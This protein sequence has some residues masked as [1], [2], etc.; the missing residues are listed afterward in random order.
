MTSSTATDAATF[1]VGNGAVTREL[2]VRDGR[3]S[4]DALALPDG[5]RIAVT[6]TELALVVATDAWRHDI[7]IW[8][9][10]EVEPGDPF[11]GAAPALDDGGWRIVPH[12]HPVFDSRTV[13]ISWFRA[14]I[15]L[16]AERASGPIHIVL[17]GLDDEDW[18]SYAA[19]LDG[20][21]LDAWTGRGRIRDPRAIVLAPGTPEHA[22]LRFGEP[23]VLAVRVEGLD[24]GEDLAPPRERE[25]VFFQGWLLDQYVSGGA[26]TRVVE[27]FRVVGTE[28]TA[29]G[30]VAV[31]LRSQAAPIEATLRYRGDPHGTRKT[32]EV[33]NVG[34]APLT[35]LDVVGDELRGEIGA[36][37]GGRGQPL[38]IGGT[39]YAGIEHP[40]GV[41]QGDTDRI[42]LVQMPG[43]TIAPGTAWEARPLVIGAAPGTHPLDAFAAY[44]RALRPRPSGRALV[45]SA[46]GWYDFTNP[47]DPLPELTQELLHENL[48]QLRELAGDG[49]PP[50]DV[51]MLDDW[52]EFSD[53]GRFRVAAFP[54]REEPVARAIRDAGMVAGLWWA[55]TRALWSSGT[56]PGVER[57]YANHPDFGGTVA[58]A[59]GTWRWLEEFGNLFIGERRF[60]L[61]SEPYRSMFM[62][63]IPAH[64][65][66]LGVT[67]LKLDCVVLHC[68]S[69]EHDHRPGRHS[70]EPM[71]DALERLLERCRAVSPDLRVVWYWGFRSPWYLGLGEMA[72]D[73]GLLMEAA[74]P[75]STPAP[76]ARQATSLNVD[77]SIEF[78]R[79]MPLELQDSLG[80]WVGDV[81]WCNRVG[82]EEWREGYL[83]DVGRG[84]DLVQ[85]WGDLT[86]LD[87]EDQ[88]FLR[89]VNRWV[90][91]LGRPGP[92]VVRI[93]GSA[94]TA[95]PYG[96]ARPA[97]G[98]TLL[99]VVNPGWDAAELRVPAGLTGWPVGDRRVVELYPRPGRAADDERIPLA[100]FELRVL[101]VL[102]AAS[103][104]AS[105]P[106]QDARAVRPT[107][108]LDPGALGWLQG[109]AGEFDL[110]AT[111]EVR[112]PEIGRGDVVWVA[113]RLVRDGQYAYDPEPQARIS[114]GATLDGLGVHFTTIPRHRDR[115][116]PGSC[117]VLRRIPAGPAWSN[118]SLRITVT[119][120]L[121]P[122]VG[123]ETTIRVVDGWWQRTRRTFRDLVG[124]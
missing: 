84:S 54:D 1:R 100:P 118:R 99:T 115:N 36:T 108:I 37:G 94:W 51:Y 19:F 63:A 117:W 87:A 55:T 42:R 85:L 17:G 30:A 96:Y 20:R 7:P 95:E 12:L 52:W 46:L 121:P 13:R 5:R 120:Q 104:P 60:C 22:A 59:G 32:I 71:I 107:R 76:T 109:V 102:P 50:F 124:G 86:L 47:A 40:A 9:W 16:P 116:G 83:L 72:F 14:R 8:R 56:A 98:G 70:V 101:A 31:R 89:D 92:E 90:R 67:L 91:R 113:H 25:H 48:T 41:N 33:R 58:L 69:S 18:S 34:K 11:D 105:I 2:S 10:R 81:A 122:D 53:L 62:A 23:L 68:T 26:A 111:A 44:V 15:T 38:V 74:T 88:A 61:A 114:F 93:G 79:S 78:A 119:S 4:T 45:Y 24:R 49:P 103:A 123:L 82:R 77:Q 65:E 27:D 3:I 35:V 112:L 110:L 80:V 106:A 39:A 73:K 6:G 75:A 28:E 66:R 97:D 29:D 21:P 57:S 43:V 64:V